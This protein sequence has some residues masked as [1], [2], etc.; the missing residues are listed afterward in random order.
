M[1][2]N[3][4]LKNMS[5]DRYMILDIKTE[6]KDSIIFNAQHLENETIH[7]IEIEKEVFENF[8]YDGNPVPE[9]H[10]PWLFHE[11]YWDNLIDAAETIVKYQKNDFTVE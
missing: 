7:E 1:A 10:K 6:T 11:N 3:Y 8:L 2:T 9:T 4:T 5:E